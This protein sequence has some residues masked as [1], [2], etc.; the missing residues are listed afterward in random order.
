MNQT[1]FNPTF[2]VASSAD[3]AY[4]LVKN[5]F[6]N[7]DLGHDTDRELKSIEVIACAPSMISY[8]SG[9]YPMLFIEDIYLK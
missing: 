7:N 6:K 9:P 1:P 3:N 5:Y 2:V 4:E 8:D